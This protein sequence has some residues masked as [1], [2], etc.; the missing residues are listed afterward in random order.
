[1]LQ[2]LFLYPFLVLCVLGSVRVG[3]TPMWRT[4]PLQIAMGS[5][6]FLPGLAGHDSC[7][8]PDRPRGRLGTL[9]S[10]DMVRVSQGT[11]FSDVA[12]SRNQLRAELT[13]SAWR[14]SQGSGSTS[15]IVTRKC[16]RAALERALTSAHLAAL[17][18]Q[19][20]PH[21]L[22]NLLHTIRGQNSVGTRPLPNQW[23]CSWAIC[24]ADC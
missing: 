20:S 11:R 10:L 8:I 2:H 18:M 3:W 14:S 17:R 24:C 4:V 5:V 16:G 9:G 12:R 23:W 7:S 15:N 13:D 19:L 22:F 6:V 21:T 1:V